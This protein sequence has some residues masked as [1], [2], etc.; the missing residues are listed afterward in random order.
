MINLYIL[1]ITDLPDP[2]DHE[3]WHVRFPEGKFENVLRFMGADDRKRS[4]GA[5]LL[6]SYALSNRGI[7]DRPEAVSFGEYGKP[8]RE[9]ICF[10][11]AHSGEYSICA[12]SDRDIGV[13][14]EKPRDYNELVATKH[15]S[16]QEVSRM[17][18]EADPVERGR[19]FVKAWSFRE[20]YMKMNGEGLH[21]GIDRIVPGT[22]RDGR[23]IA[24]VDGEPD[25]QVH[26]L[27]FMSD[28]HQITICSKEDN[29][30][31][32][33]DYVGARYLC[34]QLKLI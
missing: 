17:K 34:R 27:N 20:S 2:K 28:R 14:V 30:D 15:F 32:R 10:S 31:M 12:L 29:R 9:D 13:D 33:C 6:L 4:A 22:D 26:F 25:E 3:E 19:L 7:T 8:M 5:W 16:D 18:E 1:K 11:L 21:F 23:E 24:L